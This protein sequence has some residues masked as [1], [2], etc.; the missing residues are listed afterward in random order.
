MDDLV[1]NGTKLNWTTQRISFK[2]TSGMRGYQSPNSQCLPDKGPVPEGTYRIPL[3]IGGFASDD[4]RGQCNLAP[5]WQIQTIPR[6][7]AAGHCE[8]YWANWGNNRVRFEPADSAT[9]KACGGVRGGFY[10]HDSTKGFSHGCIEVEGSFFFR[11]KVYAKDNPHK[12]SL[13]LKIQYIGNTTY[14]KTDKN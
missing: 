10:L 12:K 4:G 11:L 5:S 9:Q 8:P 3:V 6:N 2:A 13:W 14:G 7:E 1:Y